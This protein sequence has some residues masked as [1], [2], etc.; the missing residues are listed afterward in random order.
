VHHGIVPARTGAETLAAIDRVSD[1]LPTITLPL[2]IM[3]APRTGS[4]R[5]PALHS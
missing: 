1:G 2:L 4:R 3:E 5:S